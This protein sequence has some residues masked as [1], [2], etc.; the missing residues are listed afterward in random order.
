[1]LCLQQGFVGRNKGLNS[2][3]FENVVLYSLIQVNKVV[4]IHTEW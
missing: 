4:S 3:I 1:M 2:N